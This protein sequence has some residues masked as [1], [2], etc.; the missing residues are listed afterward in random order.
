MNLQY[1]SFKQMKQLHKQSTYCMLIFDSTVKPFHL[2]Y[3]YTMIETNDDS[4]TSRAH[5]W[6]PGYKSFL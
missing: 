4:S 5:A 1:Y 2:I 6:N 3:N